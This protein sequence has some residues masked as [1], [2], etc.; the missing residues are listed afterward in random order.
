MDLTLSSRF[1]RTGFGR[2][3][4]NI[5]SQVLPAPASGKAGME[6]TAELDAVI[7]R[8]ACLS[9][10]LAPGDVLVIDT[11][12]YQVTL[13][14][15]P[16]TECCQGEFFPIPPGES[17]LSYWDEVLSRRLQMTIQCTEQYI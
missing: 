12:N 9:C 7:A 14:G 3:S 2:M 13:N 16:V 17:I 5:N 4:F 6:L 15:E 11:E 8:T 10:S 1:N